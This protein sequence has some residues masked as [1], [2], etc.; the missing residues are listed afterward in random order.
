M[1]SGAGVAST[2]TGW[3]DEGIESELLGTI[4]LDVPWS[5]VEK[6]SKIV[7]LSGT[8]EER[9]AVNFLAAHLKEWGIPHTIYEPECFISHPLSATVREIGGESRSFGAKTSAMS[10]STE[11]REIEGELVYVSST[12]DD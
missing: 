6:F 1:S 9:E 8:P 2:L 5:V 11:G 10:V 7:R 4:S 3:R 12:S